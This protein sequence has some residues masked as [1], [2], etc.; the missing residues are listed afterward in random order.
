MPNKILTRQEVK[1][2]IGGGGAEPEPNRLSTISYAEEMGATG[3][4]PIDTN[5]NRLIYNVE[6]ADTWQFIFGGSGITKSNFI[7]EL[8]G[9]DSETRLI[10]SLSFDITNTGKNKIDIPSDIE[11]IK[12]V[13]PNFLLPDSDPPFTT[14]SQILFGFRNGDDDTTGKQVDTTGRWISYGS[15]VPIHTRSSSTIKI[16]GKTLVNH[17]YFPS[18]GEKGTSYWPANPR[19]SSNWG[20]SSFAAFNSIN[21]YGRDIP[22]SFYWRA[23]SDPSTPEVYIPY[24][25]TTQGSINISQR[26]DSTIAR[27]TSCTVSLVGISEFPL[28]SCT[29]TGTLNSNIQWRTGNLVKDDTITK[30]RFTFSNATYFTSLAIEMIFNGVKYEITD[31]TAG[32]DLKTI[33]EWEF[34]TPIKVS[35]NNNEIRIS[36]NKLLFYA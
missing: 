18:P 17:S 7:V 1:N 4:L 19:T 23:N 21:I 31:Y 6:A 28:V 11:T 34:D 32:R 15:A 16:D 24:T 25:V 9:N 13:V 26:D 27:S 35:S 29:G 10:E 33:W 8:Y 5:K 14:Y 3:W 20:N 12:I 36:F 2:I 22:V 30:I